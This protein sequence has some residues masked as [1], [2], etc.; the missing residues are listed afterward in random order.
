MSSESCAA[1]FSHVRMVRRN[2]GFT[3]T[4]TRLCSPPDLP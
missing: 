2:T 3:L 1:D 4:P